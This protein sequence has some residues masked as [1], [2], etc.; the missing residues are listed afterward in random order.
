MPIDIEDE[1]VAEARRQGFQ[2]DH[3]IM[4]AVAIELV[5]STIQDGY[6]VLPNGNSLA[7]SDAVKGFMAAHSSGFT[8]LAEPTE[9][10]SDRFSGL[11]AAYLEENRRMRLSGKPEGTRHFTGKTLEMMQEII[12]ARRESAR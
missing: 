2:P 10:E 8:A 4:K 3:E 12:A 11:T 9:D 1:F 7:V 5:G 6:I